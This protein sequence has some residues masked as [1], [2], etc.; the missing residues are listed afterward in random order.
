MIS[1]S[2]LCIDGKG[3]RSRISGVRDYRLSFS[4]QQPG[5]HQPVTRSRLN[6]FQTQFLIIIKWRNLGHETSAILP[7]HVW[8]S[9][10]MSSLNQL[11]ANCAI[12]IRETSSA[13]ALLA[14]VVSSL[15]TSQRRISC[16]LGTVR[17]RR[18]FAPGA[19]GVFINFGQNSTPMLCRLYSAFTEVWFRS[20]QSFVILIASI[21][22]DRMCCNWRQCSQICVGIVAMVTPQCTFM[23][24]QR[25]GVHSSKSRPNEAVIRGS[26]FGEAITRTRTNTQ[27]WP[28]VWIIF[29]Q[30]CVLGGISLHISDLIKY[31]SLSLCI[32]WHCVGL[33][34]YHRSPFL[35]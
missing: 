35:R 19:S 18:D 10:S 27:A 9:Y 28:D 21:K 22:T 4:C 15:M 12:E 2:A 24:S 5:C 17:G 3:F 7:F 20:V 30:R 16:I 31:K 14:V 33:V 34:Y 25:V 32:H 26:V 23:T 13:A 11:T 8:S 29:D 1:I 6:S